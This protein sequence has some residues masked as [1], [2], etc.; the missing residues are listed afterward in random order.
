MYLTVAN[1]HYMLFFKKYK[2]SAENLVVKDVTIKVQRDLRYI[3]MML[4]LAMDISRMHLRMETALLMNMLY[5]ICS[6][7]RIILR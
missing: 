4:L 1:K 2:V 5:H 3:L 6:M 7:E